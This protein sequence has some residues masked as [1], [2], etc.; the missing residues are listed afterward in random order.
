MAQ[1]SII[2]CLIILASQ[3][4]PLLRPVTSGSGL[5]SVGCPLARE[6]FT[7]PTTNF[8]SS[9]VLI[10]SW[11]SVQSCGCTL[12]PSCSCSGLTSFHLFPQ[13]HWAPVVSVS[14]LGA[15]GGYFPFHSLT[16][17]VLYAWKPGSLDT[18]LSISSLRSLASKMKV[19]FPEE[20][21][22]WYLTIPSLT[23]QVFLPYIIFPYYP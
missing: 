1:A 17:L 13:S 4:I 7:F 19:M 9:E 3:L 20:L 6:L 16:L 14:L 5:S 12:L 2:S 8:W 10:W 18:A 23:F 22:F 15:V 11:Q 21:C